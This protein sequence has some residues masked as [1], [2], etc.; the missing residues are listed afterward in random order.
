MASLNDLK[1]SYIAVKKDV[2]TYLFVEDYASAKKAIEEAV[3]LLNEINKREPHKWDA[4]FESLKK[5]YAVC[6]AKL[7]EAELK[8]NDKKKD[9]SKKKEDGSDNKGQDDILVNESGQEIQTKFGDIDVTAFFDV[10]SSHPTF[11][12]IIGMEKEKDIIRDNFMLSDAMRKKKEEMEI[13]SESFIL[14]YGLPGTGKTYFAQA[15]ATEMEKAS[16]NHIE[17]LSV[18]STRVKDSKVGHTEKNINAIFDYTKQF[19][20]VILFMDEIDALLTSRQL[21]SGEPGHEGVIATFLQRLGGFSANKNLLFIAATNTPY[22]LDSAALSRCSTRLEVPLP[23]KELLKISIQRKIGSYLHEEISIDELAGLLESKHYSNR[24]I[25]MLFK[26][27]KLQALKALPED[28]PVSEARITKEMVLQGMLD[29]PSAYSA[30]E[31]EKL[32]QYREENK[33]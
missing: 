27:L 11:D 32:R 10:A 21:A 2:E 17:F 13:E 23:T 30:S 4:A 19:E 16:G 20:H 12:D 9:L 33:Y 29:H 8:Q 26:D 18:V 31:A 14:L 7:G 24:D 5:Y 3:K 25:K 28:A 1:H 6:K 22:K 15:V